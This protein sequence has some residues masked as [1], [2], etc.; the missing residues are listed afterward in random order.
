MNS[1]LR[2]SSEFLMKVL[3][4]YALGGNLNEP[5]ECGNV[6]RAGGGGGVTQLRT[7]TGLQV[8]TT[9]LLIRNLK[10]MALQELK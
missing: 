6:T 2:K 9:E 1:G 3:L 10:V 7:T 5:L 8:L 4:K